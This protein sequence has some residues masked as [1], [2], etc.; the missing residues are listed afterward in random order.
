[1]ADLTTWDETRPNGGIDTVDLLDNYARQLRTD[2]RTVFAVEHVMN[3]N[4]STNRLLS[5][6]GVHAA[7]SAV[8]YVDTEANILTKTPRIGQ[9]AITTDTKKLFLCFVASNW[10]EIGRYDSDLDVRG[11]VILDMPG[12]VNAGIYGVDTAA[13]NRRMLYLNSAATAPGRVELG[14][15]AIN[16]LL[17]ALGNMGTDIPL[18]RTDGTEQLLTSAKFLSGSGYIKML[19]DATHRFA[20]LYGSGTP[21]LTPTAVLFPSLGQTAALAI[22]TA[23]DPNTV[24]TSLTASGFTWQSSGSPVT[25]YYLALVSG[26]T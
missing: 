20:L 19:I 14:N 21:P 18:V 7:G 8:A 11:R 15:V 26:V 6:Y 12:G 25:T 5:G 23:G 1:M 9:L 10:A 17:S 13:T 3:Y 2:V 24:F 22:A 4:G 16:L